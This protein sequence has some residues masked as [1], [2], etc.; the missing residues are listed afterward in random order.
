[1]GTKQRLGRE[2][3]NWARALV[4]F[5]FYFHFLVPRSPFPVLVTCDSREHPSYK[6]TKK[7]QKA[8]R[9]GADYR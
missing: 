6:E 8:K 3:T 7:N 2:I 4:R 5:C 9:V 1:M